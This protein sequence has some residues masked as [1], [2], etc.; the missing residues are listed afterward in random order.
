MLV[1]HLVA[2]PPAET[3]VTRAVSANADLPVPVTALGVEFAGGTELVV[4]DQHGQWVHTV[5]AVQR[6][7]QADRYAAESQ[8]AAA[9]ADEATARADEATARAD[10]ATAGAD[11]L[12]ERLRAL[13]VDPDQ[14]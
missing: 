11:A 7:R 12:A 10:E 9:R 13:G 3:Y 5:A 6:A 1:R 8:Q 4:R 2:D 14:E